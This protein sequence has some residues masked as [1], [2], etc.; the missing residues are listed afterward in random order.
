MT[1]LEK[2]AYENKMRKSTKAQIRGEIDNLINEYMNEIRDRLDKLVE[3]N[4]ITGGVRYYT[5]NL[6]E[7]YHY[8]WYQEVLDKAMKSKNYSRALNYPT[9]WDYKYHAMN[10]K[11]FIE[12]TKE[13]IEEQEKL[14]FEETQKQV[15]KAKGELK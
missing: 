11:E 3:D 6:Y 4:R 12:D 8:K 5:N 13:L 10:L 1:N 7:N 9:K 15:L 2:G 14:P